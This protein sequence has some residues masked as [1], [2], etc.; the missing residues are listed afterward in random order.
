MEKSI[1]MA[2]SVDHWWC[3]KATFVVVPGIPGQ[4][5]VPDLVTIHPSFRLLYTYILAYC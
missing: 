4:R 5:A 2:C 1:T 3:G